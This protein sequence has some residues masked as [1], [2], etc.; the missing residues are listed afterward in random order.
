MALFVGLILLV[1]SKLR[2]A[3]RLRSESYAGLAEGIFLAMLGI[4]LA[5]L[6]LHAWEDS[7]VAYSIWIL[8]AT[9]TQLR[10]RL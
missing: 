8:A 1:L 10:A 9:T 6:F 3:S 7:A 5:A 4:S 2:A